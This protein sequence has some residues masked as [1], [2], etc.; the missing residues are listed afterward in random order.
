M[1]LTIGVL[2]VAPAAYLKT[3]RDTQL[4]L[5][6]NQDQAVQARDSDAKRPQVLDARVQIE[7][8]RANT[9]IDALSVPWEDLFEMVEGANAK[10]LA[11]LSL[12][13]D[14]RDHSLHLAAEAKTLE[15]M[16]AYL[17]RLGAQPML[18]DVTLVSYSTAQREGSEVIQFALV[19]KW[20]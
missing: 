13:P 4:L 17:A 8:K 7:L 11:I 9:V 12:V 3:Q 6:H 18:S 10:G 5:L 2:F 14:P 1:L 19:A 16:L 20:K 15:G